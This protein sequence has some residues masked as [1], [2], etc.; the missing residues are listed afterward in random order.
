MPPPARQ[1][2]G[3]GPGHGIAPTSLPV[4]SHAIDPCAHSR[5]IHPQGDHG[6]DTGRGP[7][8]VPRVSGTECLDLAGR[9]AQRQAASVEHRRFRSRPRSYLRLVWHRAPPRYGH[10]ADHRSLT[11][12]G[13][14]DH[15]AVHPVAAII[16]SLVPALVLRSAVASWYL[17][18]WVGLG[19]G[20]TLGASASRQPGELWTAMS[21]VTVAAAQRRLERITDPAEQTATSHRPPA[22]RRQRCQLRK[23]PHEVDRDLYQAA[24]LPPLSLRGRITPNV[25]PGRSGLALSEIPLTAPKH[26]VRALSTV[27]PSTT[28]RI[29]G[30]YAD[31]R[32]GTPRTHPVP[33]RHGGAG[34]ARNGNWH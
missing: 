26:S 8:A 23:R 16:I 2:K 18:A 20:A 30:G 13:N 7:D 32:T 21:V 5:I 10:Q 3:S 25:R 19:F 34:R 31:D 14:H 28:R 33:G 12:A 27:E 11:T 9:G 1:R 15:A 6:A 22:P 17:M 29:S 24:C 4:A